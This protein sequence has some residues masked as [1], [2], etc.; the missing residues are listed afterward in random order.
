MKTYFYSIHMAHII[1]Q[2]NIEFQG[3]FE[4]FQKC[5]KYFEN[6]D[7]NELI[8]KPLEKESAN[9]SVSEDLELPPMTDTEN[10]EEPKETEELVAKGIAAKS[11]YWKYF[12]ASGSYSLLFLLVIIIII[13]Q[14]LSSSSDYWIAYW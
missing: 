11:L 2:G 7:K 10:Q 9:R 3:N 4:D 14:L 8:E 13:A 1:L 12:Q 6:M 5:N